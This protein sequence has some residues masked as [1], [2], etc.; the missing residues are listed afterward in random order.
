[1]MDPHVSHGGASD[2]LSKL[3]VSAFAC[4]SFAPACVMVICCADSFT[5]SVSVREGL[6][7]GSAVQVAAFPFPFFYH[8]L[9]HGIYGIVHLVDL[10][11]CLF[12][13]AAELHPYGP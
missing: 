12:Y 10:P 1:M 11:M 3:I 6:G 13:G 5:T 4:A 2:W 9:E 8:A 7:S